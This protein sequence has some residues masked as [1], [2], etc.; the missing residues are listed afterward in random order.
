MTIRFK[1]QLLGD[2]RIYISK[3]TQLI[4]YLVQDYTKLIKNDYNLQVLSKYL[5]T[6]FNLTLEE[7]LNKIASNLV[8]GQNKDYIIIHID[9]RDNIDKI[10]KLLEYGNLE[11]KGKQVI[12]TILNL[13]IK[14][15][16]S[17]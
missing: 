9:K 12:S 15:L 1:K 11:V 4:R 14:E 10:A 5:K 7:A 13:S 2:S 17:I 16:Y 6:N 3:L 8:V